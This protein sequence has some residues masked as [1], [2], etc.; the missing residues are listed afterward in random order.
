MRLLKKGETLR[1]H[2]RTLNSLALRSRLDNLDDG[3]GCNRQ[4]RYPVYEMYTSHEMHRT[5]QNYKDII[6]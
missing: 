1:R 4:S 5:L 3:Q 2:R 6:P